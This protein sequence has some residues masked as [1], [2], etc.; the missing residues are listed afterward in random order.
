MKS[1]FLSLFLLLTVTQVTY[2]AISQPN[3]TTDLSLTPQLKED[4]KPISYYSKKNQ[5]DEDGSPIVPTY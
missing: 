3:L 4:L 1:A 5:D 2:G